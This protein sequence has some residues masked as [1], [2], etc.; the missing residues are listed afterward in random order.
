[1]PASKVPP[2]L[3]ISNLSPTCIVRSLSIAILLSMVR[4]RSG[5]WGVAMPLHRT[6][7]QISRP[8]AK[9]WHL[10]FIRV[11]L[12]RRLSGLSG[13]GPSEVIEH[14]VDDHAGYAD[15]EPDGQRP[16]GDGAMAVE[17][18][19]E[20]AVQRDDGQHRYR[21][22]E[23]RVCPE[24]RQIHGADEAGVLEI[25]DS[26]VGVIHEIADQKRDGDRERGDH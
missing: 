22:G 5:V 10:A 19:F 1:M 14:Q 2:V 13:S 7:V 6:I 11:S 24:N 25:H 4:I 23:R 21:G 18:A 8:G 12:S 15:V 20:P 9:Y 3:T 16:A 26:G 17:A